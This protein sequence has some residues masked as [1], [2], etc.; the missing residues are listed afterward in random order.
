MKVRRLGDPGPQTPGRGRARPVQSVG[1]LVPFTHFTNAGR[2]LGLVGTVQVL[3]AP[4]MDPLA[5]GDDVPEKMEVEMEMR[6]VCLDPGY[7]GAGAGRVS[8]EPR[9]GLAVSDLEQSLWRATGSR[10]GCGAGRTAGAW[11]QMTG[12]ET[13]AGPA[14]PLVWGHVAGAPSKTPVSRDQAQAD[15]RVLVGKNTQPGP[16]QSQRPDVP[17]Q[18]RTRP[19]SSSLSQTLGTGATSLSLV[20]SGQRLPRCPSSFP[21]QGSE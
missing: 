7:G 12:L 14:S 18:A 2:C 16:G 17:A 10:Q 11:R 19:V 4:Q 1:S 15:P 13:G 20:E 3:G 21:G 8:T 9:E 6:G 5:P